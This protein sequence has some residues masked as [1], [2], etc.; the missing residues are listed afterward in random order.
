MEKNTGGIFRGGNFPVGR[1]EFDKRE[2]HQ[3]LERIPEA[4]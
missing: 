2:V 1:G 3:G 4:T